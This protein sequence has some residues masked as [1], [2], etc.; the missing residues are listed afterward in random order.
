MSG[1]SQPTQ[2]DMR[3][4]QVNQRFIGVVQFFIAFAQATIIV[5]VSIDGIFQKD[6]IS[7]QAN[8]FTNPSLQSRRI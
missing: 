2:H 8:T 6:A 5:E 7:L 4:R 3:H 1:Y